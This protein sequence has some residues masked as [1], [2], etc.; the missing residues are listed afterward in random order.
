MARASNLV[1]ESTRKWCPIKQLSRNSI[2][3]NKKGMVVHIR[4]SKTIQFQQK[5][6][7]IPVF[8]IPKSILC[9][10]K[11]V[12]K[13]LKI[14]KCADAGPLF[15]VSRNKMIICNMLQK[16]LKELV[17]NLG[18][19][20]SKFSTHSIRRGAVVWAERNGVSHDLIQIY[21]I[22]HQM[23]INSTYSSLKRNGWRLHRKWHNDH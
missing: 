18:L 7:E 19:Q 3:F 5:V 22:G 8:A 10:V 17:G 12:C 15:A 2:I 4:W 20:K 11:A 14:N 21:G 13:L 1:P 23:C 16:K 9:P 6:L